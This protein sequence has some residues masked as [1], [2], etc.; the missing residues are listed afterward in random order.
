MVVRA[1]AHARRAAAR[2]QVDILDARGRWIARVDGLWPQDATVAEADGQVKYALTGRI[3]AGADASAPTA[4]LIDRAQRQL[5]DQRRR[6]DRLR[7]TGLQVVRYGVADVLRDLPGL[8]Q[9]VNE[10]RA[11]GAASA[12]TGRF[13]LQPALPWV[14][15]SRA[16]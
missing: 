11:A 3:I 13:R 8:A 10:R 2:A 15:S 12:F 7:D 1:A 9:Q 5:T 4:E 16:S 6:E 14:A